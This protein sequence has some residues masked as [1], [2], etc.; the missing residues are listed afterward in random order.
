MSGLFG[1]KANALRKSEA[2]ARA[3]EAARVADAT[4]HAPGMGLAQGIPSNPLTPDQ[5]EA[6]RIMRGIENPSSIR[7]GI[8][9]GTHGGKRRR[10]RHTKKRTSRKTKRSRSRSRK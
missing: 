5:L 10:R 7:A 6:A 9:A 8:I 3:A 1:P 2:N 4:K